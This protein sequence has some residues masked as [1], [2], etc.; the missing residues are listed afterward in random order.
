L[1]QQAADKLPLGKVDV[2][3]PTAMKVNQTGTVYVRISRDQQADLTKDLAGNG[4][5]DLKDSLPVS[6]S[7]KVDIKS[8]SNFK[9][10]SLDSREQLI[11]SSGYTQWSFAVTPLQSGS[12]P[13]HVRISAIISANG[14]QKNKD[15]PVKDET[16]QVSVSPVAVVEGF[17]SNNWQWLWS[18]FVIP[19]G[20]W[21][22]HRRRK[23]KTSNGKSADHLKKSSRGQGA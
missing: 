2:N 3:H 16:I 19:I 6:T 1:L 23:K 22:L 18:T 20:A 5:S 11:T 14:V 4:N 9:V 15:F 10:E 8:D 17:V 7:M 13:L 12:L 21:I